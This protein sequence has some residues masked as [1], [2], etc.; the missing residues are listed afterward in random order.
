MNFAIPYMD[1]NQIPQDNPYQ[2]QRAL[3]EIKKVCDEN[4]ISYVD[5]LIAAV[6]ALNLR[7][8]NTSDLL[9]VFMGPR[10]TTI[11]AT[12][13]GDRSAQ[14]NFCS[15]MR[16]L[17][18]ATNFM[19]TTNLDSGDVDLEILVSLSKSSKQLDLLVGTIRRVKNTVVTLREAIGNASE[20]FGS[21]FT[22]NAVTVTAN[23]SK[24]NFIDEHVRARRRL[25]AAFDADPFNLSSQTLKLPTG[26]FNILNRH[27]PD[28]VIEWEKLP[29]PV[30]LKDINAV[31][32]GWV[33]SEMTG[34]RFEIKKS[35][36]GDKDELQLKLHQ[37]P[38]HV[39]HKLA[40][41][42]RG[43]VRIAREIAHKLNQN[44]T[45][46]GQIEDLFLD[47]ERVEKCLDEIEVVTQKP[48]RFAICGRVK[49]GK[50]TTLN[51]L[52]GSNLLPTSGKW[53]FTTN[54]TAY[55]K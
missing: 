14:A 30:Y 13:L 40:E 55:S 2:I 44:Q 21:L 11:L 53:D 33:Q 36:V 10:F 15:L 23:S 12:L 54:H 41:R 19:T 4:V 28:A 42:G 38:Q 1:P 49:A 43:T 46:K 20:S 18:E 31:A 22:V 16:A 32:S 34:Y 52:L 24:N 7:I 8:C 6:D 25:V 47:L 17:T 39:F 27:I 3:E 9:D 35:D 45:W 48:L 5:D 37:G 51:V 26:S 29:K 50:S